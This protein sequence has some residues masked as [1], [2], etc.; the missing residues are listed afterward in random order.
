[1]SR[2]IEL[3]EIVRPES[4]K[5][6]TKAK[7]GRRWYWRAAWFFTQAGVV[8]AALY[9]TGAASY[10]VE[11]WGRA[12][13][14]EVRELVMSQLRTVEVVKE[15]VDPLDHSTPDLIRIVSEEMGIA[16]VITDAIIEKE[17]G[18]NNNSIRTEPRLCSKMGAQSDSQVMNCS[19]HGLMQVLGVEARRQCKIEWGQLYD[20]RTNIRCGLTILK[21]NLGAAKG[22]RTPGRQLRE[23]LRMYNGRGEDAER[24]ADSV[25]GMIADRLIT[26]IENSRTVDVQH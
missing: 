7:K 13:F 26:Q 4:P 2:T 18:Y 5:A 20:R 24:Y 11:A 10:Q 25:M 12:K 3:N 23:A 9:G 17:S 14:Y 19:S 21:N 15:Y 22:A 6:T 1:M 16:P 8:V